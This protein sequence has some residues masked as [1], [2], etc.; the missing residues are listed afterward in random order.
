[1]ARYLAVGMVLV[2]DVVLP[3]GGRQLDRLGGDAVYAAAGAR[4]FADDVGLVARLG[5]GFPEELADRLRAAGYGAGL[6]PSEHKAIRLWVE[7]GAEGG[8]RFTF[9]SGSYVGSTPIPA[10]LPPALADGLDAVH[11]A[12]VPFGQMEAWVRWARPRARILTVDPHYQHLGAD[13]PRLLP[14]VDAF[15]PSREEAAGILGVWPGA[16]GAGRA[17]ARL[18]A[19]LVCVKLGAEGSVGY[20]AADGLL[21]R[22][23]ALTARAVDPTG[24]GDAYCGGFLVGLAESGD[25]RTAMA[26][27]A[28]AAAFAAEGHGAAHM[29]NVDREEARRRVELW[30]RS[31]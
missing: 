6:I 2:E 20:R 14:H 22:V 30:R 3:D 29:L 15:L 31:G 21:F 23:P 8:A 16:E 1:M 7:P 9:Q 10:E 13:W 11:V 4:A 27:G 19:R 25:L 24:C 28:V 17:L 26:H 5:R 12:P 18:G